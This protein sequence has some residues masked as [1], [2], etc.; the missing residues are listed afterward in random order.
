[1]RHVHGHSEDRQTLVNGWNVPWQHKN[2][3]RDTN[4]T[5]VHGSPRTEWVTS[6]NLPT[7]VAAAAEDTHTQVSS[8]AS[9][10]ASL[11]PPSFRHPH[12]CPTPSMKA[13]LEQLHTAVAPECGSVVVSTPRKRYRQPA[14]NDMLK[15]TYQDKVRGSNSAVDSCRRQKTKDLSVSYLRTH[16]RRRG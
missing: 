2:T 9:A 12:S 5:T 7:K 6:P 8:E 13:D 11:E 1:M 15:K 14:K 16:Y 3:Q 10:S 4:Y